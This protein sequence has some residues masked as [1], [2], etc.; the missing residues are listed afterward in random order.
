ME[1]RHDD[2]PVINDYTYYVFTEIEKRGLQFAIPP[3]WRPVYRAFLKERKRRL[4]NPFWG[5]VG[6]FREFQDGSESGSYQDD[7][8]DKDPTLREES[9]KANNTTGLL[10]E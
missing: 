10:E 3:L 4:T 1:N 2:T 8:G 5:I 7:F 9:P 6:A